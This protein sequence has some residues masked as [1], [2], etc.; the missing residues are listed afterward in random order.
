MENVWFHFAV[1]VKVQYPEVEK[2]FKMDFDT[3]KAMCKWAGYEQDIRYGPS[4]SFF[5]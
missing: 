2:F 4:T 3:M 1:V 5:Y